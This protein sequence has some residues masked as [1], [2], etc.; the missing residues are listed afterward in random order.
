MIVGRVN[1]CMFKIA[2]N[3]GEYCQF[4]LVSL[5]ESQH[6]QYEIIKEIKHSILKVIL[7]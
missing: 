2:I 7:Q 1:G 4:E 5:L 3:K 6:W